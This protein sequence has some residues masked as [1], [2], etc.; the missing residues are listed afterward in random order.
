DGTVNVLDFT[1]SHIAMTIGPNNGVIYNFLNLSPLVS[2]DTFGTGITRGLYI[3]PDLASAA[4]WRSIE[5]VI[6]DNRLNTSGGNTGIGLNSAP[7]SKL[8]VSGTNGYSQFR[9]RT[10]YTPTS[11][12]DTNGNTGDFS[13][14]SN[15][16]YVKTP[17]GWKRSTLVNF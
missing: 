10:Q 14:D 13:W 6:G 9:L 15:Y 16:I 4:D 11:S 2:Q 5:T 3:N 1:N 12:S 7:A 17:T 8:D